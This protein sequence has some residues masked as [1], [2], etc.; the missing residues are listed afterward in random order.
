MSVEKLG[1]ETFHP[2]SSSSS[3]PPPPP[4]PPPLVHF[5]TWYLLKWQTILK[6][7]PL[8]VIVV[9]LQTVWF[10]FNQ[11]CCYYWYYL[12]KAHFW[13]Q[14]LFSLW[15]HSTMYYCGVPNYNTK[16]TTI[17]A[18]EHKLDVHKF[19]IGSCYSICCVPKNC[20]QQCNVGRWG[21]WGRTIC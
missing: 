7:S 9:C 13:F 18:A 15:I 20:R 19:N 5:D 10:T 4:S 1:Q 21:W 2:F 6:L 12:S 14:N 16:A 17:C 8:L 11:R 3:L